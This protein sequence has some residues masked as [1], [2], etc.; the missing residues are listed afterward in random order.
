MTGERFSVKFAVYIIPRRENKVLLALRKST[1][2]MDGMYSL[3]SGHVEAGETAEEAMIRETQE[4]AAVI[5]SN[6]QLKYV[7]TMQRLKTDPKD[8]YLTIFFECTDWQG[9]FINNEPEKCAGVEWFDID[10]LPEN[11]IPYIAQVLKLYPTG[12]HFMSKRG[13]V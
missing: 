12:Q 6:D 3:V 4:E 11:T 5:L 1:G 13:E 2:Y 9:E 8:D 7:F 10:K